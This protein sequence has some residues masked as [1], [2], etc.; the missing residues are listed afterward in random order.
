MKRL[1]PL[2]ALPLLTVGALC[3]QDGA[4]LPP[5][6]PPG[7]EGPLDPAKAAERLN[8]LKE[9]NPEAFKRIDANGDGTIS[10][11][12]AEAHR[13]KEMARIQESLDQAF[14]KAD[15][16]G[17]GKLDRKEFGE[18]TLALRRQM[19]P[20]GQRPGGPD[21]HEGKPGKGKEKKERK[22]RGDDQDEAPPGTR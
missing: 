12:E 4:L 6:P 5:P 19:G 1:I 16:D 13:K 10:P 15:K 7:E 17:D 14:I 8:H 9:R 3:A 18:A 2:L 11:D 22:G 20:P 21:G